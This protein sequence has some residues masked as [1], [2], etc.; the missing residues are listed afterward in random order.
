MWEII[1]SGK[2]FRNQLINR[3]KNGEIYYEQKTITPVKDE[4][5][6]V[7][8][9]VSTSQDITMTIE[10]T[11]KLEKMATTD[12][13][14]GIY[15]RHRFEELFENELIRTHRYG[16]PFSLIMF[17]I[18]HFKQVNDTYGHDVG[19]HVLKTVVEII[20]TTL[21]VNDI[22][23]RWGG[24]EF[25][26]LCPETTLEIGS[27][28]AE[29]LRSFIEFHS[30]KEVKHITASFGVIEANKPYTK[31]ELLKYVDEMLYKAKE[32][33]RNTI[34]VFRGEQP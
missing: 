24:E 30:F 16:N 2:V 31:Q 6:D 12:Q 15:N 3:K 1:L 5:G 20:Q 13:L 10:M 4:Y 17:D 29:K 32:G 21:R 22:F 34:E 19:D 25:L 33:G 26:I 8:S 28:V 7:I 27:K 9:F 23:A 18:D 14:T 11:K